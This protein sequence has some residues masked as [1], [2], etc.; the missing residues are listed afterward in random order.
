MDNSDSEENNTM[1]TPLILIEPESPIKL[2]TPIGNASP[3]VLWGTHRKTGVIYKR[4]DIYYS[5]L[6]RH[7]A[8][9][10]LR[11]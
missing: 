8:R 7:S 9:I 2:A 6:E 3:P 11:K 5:N 10:N 1:L 4:N